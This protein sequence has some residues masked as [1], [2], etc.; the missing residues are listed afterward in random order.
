MNIE[1]IEAFVYAIHLG[2]FVKAAEALYLTQP[3][4]TARIHSLERELNA[5]LFHRS[6]KQ[7]SI[8]EK[9]KSFLPYAQNILQSYQEAKLR[10]HQ[11]ILTLDK[12][13]IG[14]AT[15]IANYI[16]PEI[17]PAFKTKFPNVNV[18]IL[19]GHSND[20]LDKVLNNEV[21]FG[22]VRTVTHPQIESVIFRH[23]PIG[24]FVPINHSLLLNSQ[25]TIEEVSEEPL[26]FFDYGS[27]DW[28]MIYGL[29]ESKNL[30]PN[31][32]LEVDSMEAAKNLVVNGMGISFLPEHCVKKELESGQLFRVPLVSSG[33][34]DVKIDFIYTKENN[35][36]PYIEYFI[37]K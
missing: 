36:P 26:I 20:I 22:M 4:V 6:G 35:K 33:R 21:D 11:P 37:N 25:V 2:S 32:V 13:K 1:N 19:T 28:L 29:F 3:S 8:N 24:L 7:I 23:D 9:G 27:V 31:V 15:S 16:I 34:F 18:N 14:C 17:L 30:K 5:E 12:L 10:L